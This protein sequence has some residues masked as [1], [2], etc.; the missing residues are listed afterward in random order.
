MLTM[1]TIDK[2]DNHLMV[3]L[4]NLPKDNSR[5]ILIPESDYGLAEIYRMYDVFLVF[6]IPTYGGTPYFH[7]YY[8]E[9]NV[10]T[11]INDLKEIC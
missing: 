1:Q 7:K 3:G 10:D 9:C 4:L 6:L 8:K 2:Y 11:L 5:G